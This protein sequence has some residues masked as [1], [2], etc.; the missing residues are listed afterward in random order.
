[1]NGYLILCRSLTNAQQCVKH[2]ARYRI[3]AQ[4]TKAPLHLRKNGCGY[5]V[6]CHAEINRCVQ[7]LREAELLSGKIYR[8]ENG[9]YEEMLL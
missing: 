9:K 7:I 4:V 2:L 6:S 8:R 3:F 1:M 5:A